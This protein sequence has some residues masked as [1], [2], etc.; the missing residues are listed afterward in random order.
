MGGAG[1]EG[2]ARWDGAGVVCDAA[3]EMCRRYNPQEV[4]AD[5]VAARASFSHLSLFGLYAPVIV[6]PPTSPAPALLAKGVYSF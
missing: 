5:M 1:R 3:H 4:S 2:E 6:Y